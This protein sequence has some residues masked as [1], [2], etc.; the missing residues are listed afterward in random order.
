M[1]KHLAAL[2]AAFATGTAPA[3]TP[4]L[5][6]IV[7]DGYDSAAG[8]A[9]DPDHKAGLLGYCAGLA[10]SIA[11]Q[12]ASGANPDPTVTDDTQSAVG[13]TAG[14]SDSWAADGVTQY[15][16]ENPDPCV[17][18][19]SIIDDGPFD[20][21]DSS[22]YGPHH[23]GCLCIIVKAP[24]DDSSRS[25]HEGFNM[26]RPGTNNELRYA[27]RSATVA[28]EGGKSI[29]RGVPIVYNKRT[30]IHDSGPGGG[31]GET[32]RPTALDR[33][34]RDGS[35]QPV[36][37]LGHDTSSIPLAS[38]RAGTMTFENRSDGL[39]IRAEL[40]SDAYSQSVAAAAAAGEFG[41]SFVL[42]CDKGDDTWNSDYSERTV[43]NI[44]RCGETTLT[45]F[46]A[47]E[48]T[49]GQVTMSDRST[50]SGDARIQRAQRDAE[51]ALRSGKKLSASTVSVLQQ[52][53]TSHKAGTKAIVDLLKATGNY[54]PFAG[55]ANTQPDGTTGQTTGGGIPGS[56]P[57]GDG[58]GSRTGL[59]IL[60]ADLRQLT[61]STA[62]LHALVIE[63]IRREQ[64]IIKPRHQVIDR[65]V[66]ALI[67]QDLDELRHEQAIARIRQE[68]GL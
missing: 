11:S 28:D 16:N 62:M 49:F 25:Q 43:H 8:D 38:V 12:L 36:L 24:A 22:G 46:P 64:G 42:G 50:N 18:C 37:L 2:K 10:V 14:T 39:H 61:A 4:V 65:R 19:Q 35:F 59:D 26:P 17:F 48:G 55:N 68:A 58:S 32:I 56:V 33:S 1:S 5:E 44:S 57:N 30:F 67:A 34:I 47:Y 13:A 52:A 20:I 31:F 6:D 9:A 7:G 3:I 54:A 27:L 45:P 63:N 51:D 15:D 66:R 40:K 23:P 41:M 21:G 29:L 60:D 53:V